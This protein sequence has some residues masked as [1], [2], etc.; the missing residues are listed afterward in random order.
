M[1]KI[2]VLALAAALLVSGNVFAAEEDATTSEETAVTSVEEET[3]TAEETTTDEEEATTEEETATDEEEATTEEETTDEE[4]ATTE[5]EEASEEETTTS[6]EEEGAASAEE[7]AVADEEK[8]V[9]VN[10]DGIAL[11]IADQQP[12]IEGDRVL[13]PLRAI[14]EALDA[15]VEWDQETKTVTAEK[16]ENTIELTIGETAYTVN[17]EEKEMDVAA[18][19]VNDRTLVPIRVVSESLACEVEWDSEGYIVDVSTPEHLAVV[20]EADRIRAIEPDIDEAYKTVDD[21]RLPIK[22]YLSDDEVNGKTAILAIHG[23]SWYAVKEDSDTWNGGW[24]NY[25]AQYYADKGYTTAAISYRS[26]DFN[27]DTTVFDL[28]QDCKDAV[29]Y[30]REKADFDKLVVMGDSSGGHL[31]VELGLDDE[32]GVDIVVAANPVLDLTEEA[33]AHTAKTEED[34]IKA[35]PALNI[36]QTDTKFLVMHGNADTVVNYE[37]SK[38]FCEDMT[39][40]GTQADFIELDGVDHAFLLSRYKSTDEQINEYMAMID[41][42]L[43][44]NL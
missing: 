20:A 36:K 4:T 26:I 35:S 32:V 23:G 7:D 40:E 27:E 31:A 37:I 9:V 3:T 34:Y 15:S 5:G 21:V 19:L 11:E 25:Q 10:I 12:I 30:M 33:W 8:T 22:M 39:A 16:G 24:M 14:F 18:Q 6:D 42:Y 17:G 41:E 1:K 2:I 28:I 38:K 44:E 29:A 43:A 13:V